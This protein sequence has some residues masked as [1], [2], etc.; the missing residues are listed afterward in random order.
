MQSIVLQDKPTN[1]EAWLSELGQ[2]QADR[3]YTPGHQRVQ[4]LLLALQKHGKKL[5]KPK[6]RIRIAGTNG[7]GSTAHFLAY[8]LQATGLKVGLYTSPHISSFHE[9][10]KMQGEA[11][12]DLRLT[13][14]MAE[15]MPLAL[16]VGTSYFETATVLALLA[17]S[18]ENVDVEILEAG[19]GA[20]LDATTAVI[21]DV[22]LLTPIALDHE[23][24]LGTTLAAIAK[25]K[26][27]VFKGCKTNISAPQG[28]EVTKVLLNH[29]ADMH[30]SEHF[31]HPLSTLGEH[32]RLNAGL[33]FA[34]V[35][36]LKVSHKSVRNRIDLSEC[37]RGISE[38]HIAGRLERRMHQKH[39]FYLDA[40][41]NHHAIASLF[42]ALR[43]FK[44]TFDVI[45]LC[46]REDRDLSSCIGMLQPYANEVIALTG[47][48]ER[49]Y[50][51]VGDALTGHVPSYDAGRFLVLGSFVTL[52]ETLS[53]MGK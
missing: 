44:A 32:Q 11:I 45:F 2:P 15:V 42:P 37:L 4:D 24:W 34:A 39:E 18:M 36:A 22:A 21:A 17:F 41:H 7:K 23:A 30:F 19:V 46:T 50:L 12:D 8:A 49:P 33:A 6:L 51:S 53:W 40:A 3:D 5:H 26:S 38:T 35:K 25:D 28:E 16:H 43:Q 52:G 27:C 9:R 20:K 31:T 13:A 1:I 47:Y 10:I 29:D 14:L 48:K